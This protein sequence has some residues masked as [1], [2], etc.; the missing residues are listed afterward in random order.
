MMNQVVDGEIVGRQENIANVRNAYSV[1]NVDNV[2]CIDFFFW[3]FHES[4][5]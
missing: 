5:F 4:S 1:I 3:H 2:L